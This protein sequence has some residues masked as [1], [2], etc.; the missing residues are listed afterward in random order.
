MLERAHRLDKR[1]VRGSCLASCLMLR[2]CVAVG[3][4]LAIVAAGRRGVASCLVSPAA[5]K[6]G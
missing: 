3:A 1:M 6:A 5:D 4:G 2:L